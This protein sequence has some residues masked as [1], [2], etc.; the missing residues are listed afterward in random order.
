MRLKYRGK[1]FE[2]EILASIPECTLISARGDCSCRSKLVK[3]EN[4]KVMK[5]LLTKMKL[6]GGIDLVYIDPPFATGNIF[7]MS[8]TKANAISSSQEDGI[9]Y[10]DE[11]T[12]PEYIEFLRERLILIRRLLSDNGSVYVHIDD[13]IGH[14]VKVIMDEVFGADRFIND[15]A[16]VKC[17][18]KNFS[19]H[20][21]GNVKDMILFYSKTGRYIWNEQRIRF[22][23]NDIN[24][25]FK[26]IDKNG[27]RY[28]T[29]PVHAPGET[30][31]GVTGQPWRGMEP[32]K[33]RHWRSNPKSLDE[34]DKQ[35]LI[36][37]SSK[38]VP[39]KIL[40]ADE[41]QKDGMKLQDI[42]EFKDTQNP[43]YPTEKNLELLKLLVS[44]SSHENSVVLDCFC[45]SGTTLKA[46]Q[47]LG[48][49]WIGI[50]QSDMAIKIATRRLSCG[51]RTLH[52]KKHDFEYL[53][54]EDLS[55][56]DP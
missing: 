28:T 37:W 55:N 44:T 16:R 41:K 15:I 38:G 36:E 13:K 19:R 32:P 8:D 46:A 43:D 25:L 6:E 33:G 35:G 54:Q 17:N 27:R 7:R 4:L 20:A 50:D 29:I 39:R 56:F 10:S 21:F 51:Q 49:A 40:Y 48:R 23:E 47:D 1:L 12:G 52:S 24:R 11:L 30:R 53:V 45:G 2:D 18:P 22:S 5:H 14:Y 26:K 34:L 42:L 3:G 9:A 31:N